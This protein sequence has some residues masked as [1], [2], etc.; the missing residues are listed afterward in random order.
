MG[1]SMSIRR[2]FL[3]RLCTIQEISAPNLIIETEEEKNY[4][5]Q[6]ESFVAACGGSEKSRLLYIKCCL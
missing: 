1:R 6:G 4:N 2:Y 3:P 5:C